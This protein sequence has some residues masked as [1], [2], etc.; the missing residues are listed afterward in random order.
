MQEAYWADKNVRRHAER[1]L[2]KQKRKEAIEQQNKAH[3]MKGLVL[4]VSGL[5]TS[6]EEQQVPVPKLKQFFEPYGTPAYVM[7]DGA[8]VSL[9]GIEPNII[10]NFIK[11][12]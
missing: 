11:S 3:Y 8:E 5:P 7:I 10:I 1:E 12:Q 4:K 2:K 9:W 6:S